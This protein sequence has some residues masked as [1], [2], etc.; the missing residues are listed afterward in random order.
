MKQFT[1]EGKNPVS[2]FMITYGFCLFLS[3]IFLLIATKSSPL[4]PFNDWV[5]VNAF[6]TGGKAMMN[7]RILYRDVFDHKGPLFYLLFGLAYLISN[8]LF[9]GVFIFEVISF[10]IFLFFSFKLA[11][12]FIDFNYSL[13]HSYVL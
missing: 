10:S 5:D 6:F 7:G 4:Y 1:F 3:I 11:S 8:T 2:R 9:L 12:L 13:I